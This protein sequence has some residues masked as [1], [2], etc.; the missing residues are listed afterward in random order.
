MNHCTFYAV[1]HENKVPGRKEW[2][3]THEN[4]PKNWSSPPE[5][6]CF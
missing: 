1:W 4:L 3:L 5:N 2:V 6:N